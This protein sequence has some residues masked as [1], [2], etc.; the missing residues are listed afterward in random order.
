MNDLK[1][2]KA[3]VRVARAPIESWMLGNDESPSD[4]AAAAMRVQRIVRENRDLLAASTNTID[5]DLQRNVLLSDQ[6][7]AFKRRIIN[8][9][10]FTTRFHNVPVR[11]QGGTNKV[12]VPYYPLSTTASEDFDLST[13]YDTEVD[14]EEGAIVITLNKRKYQRFSYS[15][16]TASRQP[17]FS[18]QAH[19]QRKAEQL[20]LDVWL[21]VLSLITE[22]NF[23]APVKTTAAAGF[24]IEDVIDLRETA[25][26]ADWPEVGRSLVIDPTYQG[27]MLKSTPTLMSVSDA[28]T[29]ETLRDG[30]VGRLSGFNLLANPRVPDNSE[31]LAGFICTAS[32]IVVATAPVIP[33]PGV[34]NRLVSYD[35]VIDP[36]TGIGFSYRHGGDDVLDR[37]HHIIECAYGYAKGEAAALK[38]ITGV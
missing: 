33:A 4:M 5:S 38:R 19:L 22:A 17:A 9:G 26:K 23:G 2:I 28:G 15:S 3:A 16:E 34:R 8:L 13:G 12:A 24:D 11:T 27:N 7:F 36:D 32:A 20:G 18:A 6:L 31:A 14:T 25:D 1:T 35:L 29:S 37:D 30:T 21:D 10:A